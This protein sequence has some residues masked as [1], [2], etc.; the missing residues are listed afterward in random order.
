MITKENRPTDWTAKDTLCA[1]IGSAGH[2]MNVPD[3]F[4]LATNACRPLYLNT[5]LPRG[6]Y[7][8][9]SRDHAKA[10]IAKAGKMLADGGMDRAE[11]DFIC[12]KLRRVLWRSLPGRKMEAADLPEFTDA[13]VRSE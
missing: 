5:I 7:P 1:V 10:A 11:Y 9:I 6:W 12:E 8:G 3:A 2:D 13:E 4:R